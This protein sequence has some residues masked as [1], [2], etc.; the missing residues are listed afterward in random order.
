MFGQRAVLTLGGPDGSGRLAV[1]SAVVD[2]QGDDD[3]AL[4]VPD[5]S[6]RA[7][8][9]ARRAAAFRGG[10]VR[11]VGAGGGG[12]GRP[13]TRTAETARRPH[14]NRRVRRSG[15]L[16]VVRLGGRASPSAVCCRPD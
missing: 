7:Q 11:S 13:V 1:R 8:R 9:V 10:R 12:G 2:A 15:S 3:G 16:R 6:D 4:P 14:G 5:G